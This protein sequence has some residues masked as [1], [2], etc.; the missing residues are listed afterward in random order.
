MA[1]TQKTKESK[2]AQI[3]KVQD[4]MMGE[5]TVHETTEEVDVCPT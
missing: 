1:T 4:D 3:N 2:E 5:G